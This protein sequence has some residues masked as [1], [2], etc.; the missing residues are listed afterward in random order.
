MQAAAV[1]A[2]HGYKSKAAF[3]FSNQSFFSPAAEADLR[4]RRKSPMAIGHHA[5]S[6]PKAFQK[7]MP[8]CF[9]PTAGIPNTISARCPECACS[10]QALLKMQV[11]DLRDARF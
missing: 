9:Q 8:P 10:N 4:S 2:E 6:P 3:T 7:Q 5:F 1:N 11:L